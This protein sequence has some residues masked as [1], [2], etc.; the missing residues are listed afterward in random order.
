LAYAPLIQALRGVR[1]RVGEAAFADV[2]GPAAATVGVLLGITEGAG[3]QPDQVFEQLLGVLGRLADRQPTLLVFEDLHW[4]DAST[5]DLV[6]FLARNLREVPVGLVLTYRSDEL[7]RR[8]PWLPVLA[9][10]RRDP[11][12]ERITLTG[13]GRADVAVLVDQI[14]GGT[15]ASVEELAHRTG[16]NPFYVEELVAARGLGGGCRRRWPR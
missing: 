13:L 6:T 1:H 15:D 2:L 7:H 16:G 12:V 4:A 3:G 10:L 9:D 8:H 11:L 14:G 5:R